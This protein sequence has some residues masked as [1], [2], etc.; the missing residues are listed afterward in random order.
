MSEGTSS[1]KLQGLEQA[2]AEARE[3]AEQA[4]SRY[5]EHKAELDRLE[6]ER[7]RIDALRDLVRALEALR[8]QAG[9][10]P[11]FG[12]EIDPARYDR[13][14]ATHRPA[15]ESFDERVPAAREAW[16]RA[17]ADW[18]A[19]TAEIGEAESRL[20]KERQRQRRA[21]R[22]ERRRV[23]AA[24]ARELAEA[25]AQPIREMRV[26]WGG[27]TE[28]DRRLKRVAALV[29]LLVIG[30]SVLLPMIRL[31]L[32]EIEEEPEV[33]E[34]LAELVVE[35]EQEPEPEPQEPVE[36]EQQ[37]EEQPEEQPEEPPEEEPEE[38]PEVAETA[39]EPREEAPE[40]TT[41]AEAEARER[42]SQT[43]L[44]AM[45]DELDELAD[46]SVE[47]KLGD[48]AD[49]SNEGS[50]ESE[51]SRD[52]VTAEAGQSSGGIETEELSRNVG[53]SGGSVGSRETSR[54]ESALA[55]QAA[56]GAEDARTASGQKGR[57]DEDIQIVFDRNKSA[58]YR[59]YNRALR[60]D[61][62]LEGKVT[63][64]L[65]IEPS[66]RVSMCQVV[67]SDLEAPGVERKIVQRVKLFDFGAKDVAPV[68][69]T[70]P[71]DFLPA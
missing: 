60:R 24:R 14:L 29:F 30:V 57:T 59:I 65:T 69:I 43:G 23:L 63:L 5:R 12:G 56:Q 16:N 22:E 64:K 32:P 50:E 25:G 70:Y 41:T 61:P 21:E 26:A 15:I 58:L 35:R 67:A 11:L 37:V 47:D 71:I 9:E 8:E 36:E 19:A 2:L 39:P 10:C 34:R 48:Q 55:K 40:P 46:S 7:P 49:I 31:P 4:E 54:V 42:A 52:I 13:M 53:G 27:V 33:P 20:E 44:L 6:A 17:E 3:R 66:G 51:V 62:S 1:R 18:R 38:E 68:T 28:D 45:S